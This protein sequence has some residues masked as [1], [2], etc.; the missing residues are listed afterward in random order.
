VKDVWFGIHVPPEGRD[1]QEMERMCQA[2]EHNGFGLFTVT[3][4]LMNMQNPAVDDNHPLESW[5]T[6]AVLAAVT[7]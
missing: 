3:D 4:Y 7:D 6:L 1:F 5:T 2:V